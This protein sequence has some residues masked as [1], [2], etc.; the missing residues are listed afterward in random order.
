MGIKM[1]S[2]RLFHP[3][4]RY[5][6]CLI[7]SVNFETHIVDLPFYTH[8]EQQYDFRILVMERFYIVWWLWG[9]L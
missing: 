2:F 7:F 5:Q 9:P 4:G 1:M 3:F 8:E 6:T